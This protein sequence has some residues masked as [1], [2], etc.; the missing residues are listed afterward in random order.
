M[1]HRHTQSHTKLITA[2]MGNCQPTAS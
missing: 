2:A 1:T